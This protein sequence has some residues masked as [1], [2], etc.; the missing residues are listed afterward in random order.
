MHVTGPDSLSEQ[1]KAL[2]IEYHRHVA[3]GYDDAVTRHYHFYHVHSLHKWIR[4]LVRKTPNATALDMGTGTG[5]V[6]STLASFG[7]RVTAI[8]HSLDMLARATQSAKLAGTVD[9]I[10]FDYGDCEHLTYAD[11]SFDAVTI[12]G[13]IHH[14]PDIM[15]TL[16][17]A[18]RVLKPGGELYISEPCL[19][20]TWVGRASHALLAPA[21]WLRN[22]LAG[23]V[24]EPDV[25]DHEKPISGPALVHAVQS[26]G[27]G[28]DV[29]YLVQFG[30]VRLL[31][32]RFKIW[33]I[34]ALSLPT[35][36]RYGDLVFICGRKAAHG[37]PVVAQE[38]AQPASQPQVANSAPNHVR[39][40]V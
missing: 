24:R 5:V 32:E 18:V 40:R 7:C 39:A 3:K 28:V 8:D 4:R 10:K 33:V 11:N 16:R 22:K 21:R 30:A 34:L 15:P 12:Q 13:V 36:R 9:R 23:S 17:E 14:L 27:I 29:E 35:R 37:S 2:D 1:Q 19:E 20:T 6:A 26:L 31:P 38:P 25:S